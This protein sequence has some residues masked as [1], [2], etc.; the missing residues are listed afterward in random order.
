LF[1]YEA[2][3]GA[4]TM[5]QGNSGTQRIQERTGG[6]LQVRSGPLVSGAALIG[7][8]GLIALVGVAI[9]GFHL[10]SAV[11]QWVAEMET[12]PTE[13]AKQKVA[14]ARAAAAAASAAG[15]GAWQNA[16]ADSRATVS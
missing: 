12:S 4:M 8:G 15:Q 6:A 5:T 10:L 1:I 14:Q 3:D 9:G 16:P 13:L 11:R 2:Q 7:I